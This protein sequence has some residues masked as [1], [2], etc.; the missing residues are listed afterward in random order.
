LQFEN[1]GMTGIDNEILLA[2]MQGAPGNR[3]KQPKGITAKNTAKAAFSWKVPSFA[4][5]AA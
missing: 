2:S 3:V 4:F 5:V 1:S